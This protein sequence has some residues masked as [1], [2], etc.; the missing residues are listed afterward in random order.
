MASPSERPNSALSDTEIGAG[1]RAG[2]TFSGRSTVIDVRRYPQSPRHATTGATGSY[3]LAMVL[4]NQIIDRLCQGSLVPLHFR[5][6]SVRTDGL[7]RT[8]KFQSSSV[9]RVRGGGQLCFGSPTVVNQT[10][11]IGAVKYGAMS[12]PLRRLLLCGLL[13]IRG[14]TVGEALMRWMDICLWVVGPVGRASPIFTGPAHRRPS[15]V[16]AF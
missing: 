10:E 12:T 15:A 11:P 14:Q 2:R 1:S 4:L 5:L 13:T 3:E 16:Q 6:R 8:P 7:F 9:S